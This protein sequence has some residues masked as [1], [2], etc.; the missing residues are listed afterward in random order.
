MAG[1]RGKDTQPEVTLRK[2]LF[3]R[4]YRYRLH[5][6]RLPGRPDL[7]FPK[8]HAVIFV[9]GCFW[10]RHRGCR[11]STKP[12][13]RPEF[14]EAKLAGNVERHDRQAAALLASG[15]R[16]RV[17]WECDLRRDRSAVV[18]ATVAWLEMQ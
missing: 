9:H 17:V 11:F 10:H 4:G 1:I 6:R 2:A 3:A 15:W 8:W 12:A 13:T 16:V 7:V 18:D 14:W 5:D